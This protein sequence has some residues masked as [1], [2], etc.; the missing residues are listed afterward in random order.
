MKLARSPFAQSE[1]V[2]SR[3]ARYRLATATLIVTGWTTA[4]MA[5]TPVN[6]T[7]ESGGMLDW[8]VAAGLAA[9]VCVAGFWN[10]KRSHQN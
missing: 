9:V 5:Q 10:P 1:P 6:I 2:C 3:Q 4:L 7:E 8:A